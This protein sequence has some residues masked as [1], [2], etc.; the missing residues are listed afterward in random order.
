MA[1]NHAAASPPTSD[2]LDLLDGFGIVEKV[3]QDVEV[4]SVPPTH[5]ACCASINVNDLPLVALGPDVT[6]ADFPSYANVTAPKPTA[7]P[8]RPTLFD[9]E[10]EYLSILVTL[11]EGA[12]ID[13]D[14]ERLA[15]RLDEVDASVDEKV[16]G[17]CKFIRSVESDGDAAAR[18]AARLGAR[19][20]SFASAGKRLRDC[21]RD[22]LV[23]L[24]KP[25]V[26]TA[27]FTVT[28]KKSPPSVASVSIPD[29][30]S[31]FLKP[32]AAPEVDR[33]AI[34]D[35]WKRTKIA[36]PGTTIREDG[37]SLEIR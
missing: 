22:V 8:K 4:I 25:K 30:P 24:D 10:A 28:V 1:E 32:P 7:A 23:R 9:L 17:W 21:L 16:Q 20:Q 37:R 12:N 29:L 13:G 19:A 2:P 36:P 26:K 3:P 5:G 11:D 33:R 27:L 14:L 6:P 15:M 31:K 34:L 18:E 35:E